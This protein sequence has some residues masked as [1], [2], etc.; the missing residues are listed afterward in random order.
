MQ[1][2]AAC[3]LL[4]MLVLVPVAAPAQQTPET[5]PEPSPEPVPEPTPAPAP[6][7]TP[8]RG[9][10][11]LGVVGLGG[12]PLGDF[13][14]VVGAGFGV[15]TYLAGPL[16]RGQPVFLRLEFSYLEY[17]S[18]TVDATVAGTGGRVKTEDG[19]HVTTTSDFLRFALGPH[20]A[21]RRGRL[22]PYGYAT[23]GA[24]YF[25]TKSDLDDD[26]PDEEAI[27][28]HT[29]CSDWTFSWSA[30]AGV[31][32]HLSGEGFLDLGV[33]YLANRPVDWMAA[34]DVRDPMGPGGPQPRHSAVNLFEIVVGFAAAPR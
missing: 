20:V 29:N 28:S 10:G 19:L 3:G 22:R 13:A 9:A 21:A 23:V 1:H 12:I 2:G 24:S 17:G 30:G 25:S 8:S 5:P 4:A 34:G 27:A 6:S 26:A 16:H 33:R 31:L 11:A 32:V 15:S 18:E 14:G 7:P